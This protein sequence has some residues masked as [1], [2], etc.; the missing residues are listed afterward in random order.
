MWI[1]SQDKH[2]LVNCEKIR[3]EENFVLG[4]PLGLNEDENNI[5]E[6]ISEE[7]ALD[8]LIEIQQYAANPP[9][10]KEGTDGRI[11]ISNGVYQ[12]PDK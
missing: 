3:V 10:T 2:L 4:S 8:V 7:R 9:V 1:K 5:G 12:M 11:I 6:Y